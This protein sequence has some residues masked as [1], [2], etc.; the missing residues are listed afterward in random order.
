VA[1]APT[2]PVDLPSTTF[3]VGTSAS[4]AGGVTSSSGKSQVAVTGPVAQDGPPAGASAARGEDHSSS[5]EVEDTDW[6]CPWPKEA[7]SQQIDEQSV[8]IQVVVR[9]DGTPESARVLSDPGHGFAAA[10]RACALATH[11]SPAHD[12]QGRALRAESPP[13]LVHF[14]R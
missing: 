4:Y 11:Y 9:P 12:R 5:I 6:N 13:I 1:A 2:T 8:L 3:V 14:T 7:D 10:A